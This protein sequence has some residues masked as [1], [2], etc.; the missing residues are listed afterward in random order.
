VHSDRGMSGGTS[1][2]QGKDGPSGVGARA[3]GGPA[4]GG[5][6]VGATPAQAS[7][8]LLDFYRARAAPALAHPMRGGPSSS[9][10]GPS[11]GIGAMATVQESGSDDDDDGGED[12]ARGGGEWEEKD[13]GKAGR[14]GVIVRGQSRHSRRPVRHDKGSKGGRA[15]RPGAD[16]RHATSPDGGGGSQ[17][18]R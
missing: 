17:R 14:G 4:P 6:A 3:R 2:G 13:D 8:G 11:A 16:P 18:R 15:G 9:S 12:A 1:Q 5:G 10:T 7:V